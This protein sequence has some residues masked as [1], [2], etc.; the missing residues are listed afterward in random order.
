MTIKELNGVAYAIH[1]QKKKKGANK[2]YK[3]TYTKVWSGAMTRA[4][5]LSK[6]ADID[7]RECGLFLCK[8]EWNDFKEDRWWDVPS[9]RDEAVKSYR[10]RIKAIRMQYGLSKSD[11]ARFMRVGQD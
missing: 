8:V 5:Y 6:L 4:E 9:Y 11:V 10:E 7:R 1:T 2:G 3:Y